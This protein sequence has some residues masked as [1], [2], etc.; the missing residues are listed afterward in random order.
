MNF[1]ISLRGYSD[2]AFDSRPALRVC[3][4]EYWN[5]FSVAIVSTTAVFFWAGFAGYDAPYAEFPLVVGRTG[6]LGILVG[7]DQKDRHAARCFSVAFLGHAGDMPVVVNNRCLGFYY[8]AEKLWRSRSCRSS[9]VVDIPV[10]VQR[11]IPIFFLLARPWRLRSCSL[12][13]GGRCPVVDTQ[14]LWHLRDAK[15]VSCPRCRFFLLDYEWF[16]S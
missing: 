8:S 5:F 10:V 12:F 1:P 15:P 6:M 16:V 3:R 2:P 14:Y 7:M 13:P 9:Q 11:P 4:E